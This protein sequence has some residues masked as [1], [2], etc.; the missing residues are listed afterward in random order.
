MQPKESMWLVKWATVTAELVIVTDRT[1]TAVAA[2][3]A[4]A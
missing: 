4:A 1:R 3:A 2:A